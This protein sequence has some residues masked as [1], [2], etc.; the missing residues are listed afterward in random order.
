[1]VLNLA[2]VSESFEALFGFVFVS[3]FDTRMDV[4][5]HKDSYSLE[6]LV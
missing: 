2:C 6:D 5:L 1:M 4:P 3:V